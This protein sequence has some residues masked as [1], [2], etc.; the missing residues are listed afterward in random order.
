MKRFEN[1]PPIEI[2][3]MDLDGNVKRLKARNMS[4][5]DAEGMAVIMETFAKDNKTS[6]ANRQMA[7]IFGGEE[8]DYEN[9]DMRIIT[10]A[11]NYFTEEMNSPLKPQV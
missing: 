10:A 8:K 7:F 1:P 4:S 6:V 5:K 11:L 3:I 2:E 9:Y